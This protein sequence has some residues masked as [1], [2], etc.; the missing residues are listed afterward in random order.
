MLGVLAVY[1]VFEDE[2]SDGQ[3]KKQLQQKFLERKTA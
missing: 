3:A 1:L 2:R